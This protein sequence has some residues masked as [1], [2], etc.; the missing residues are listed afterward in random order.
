MNWLTFI[1]VDVFNMTKEGVYEEGDTITIDDGVTL[2]A[3]W[4]DIDGSG[5]YVCDNGTEKC[6]FLNKDRSELLCPKC[7][8]SSYG[9]YDHCGPRV[10]FIEDEQ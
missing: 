9:L 10:I 4:A 5:C 6:Y 1:F 8:S 7:H 3:V 2:K